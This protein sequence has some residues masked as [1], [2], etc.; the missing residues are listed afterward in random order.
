[1]KLK[2]VFCWSDISGYMAACWRALHDADEVEVFVIAFK[3]LTESAFGDRLMQD[4]PCRLLDLQ[5]RQ[6]A[7][8]IQQLVVAQQP[9]VVVVCGWL[10]QPYCQLVAVDRLKQAAFVMG[11]DTPWKDNWR[12][13]LAPLVLRSYLKQIDR[14]VVTGE[15]SWQYARHLGIEPGRIIR[16]L[17]GIDY[18]SWLPLWSQRSQSDWPRSFLFVGRYTP[19]K[20][21]D[22]LVRA[23]Q[24]Y[25]ARVADPWDLVCCGQ[26]DLKSLLADK[27]GIIDRGFMQPAEM[28]DVWRSAGAFILPSRFDPWP[29]AIVE[30][31]AAGLPIICTDVCGSAVEVVRSW[32]NG[33]VIPEEDPTQLTAALLIFDRYHAQL[34]LW[35][36]RSQELAAPYATSI[37]VERWQSL[38]REAVTA[39]ST[40]Q[41]QREFLPLDR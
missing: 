7:N 15:R 24:D 4:V 14:V 34:P 29:L 25:R 22:V 8:S 21:V 9:D 11:M 39:K 30:A 38:L 2:V 32:Y 12:Q 36:K 35:G 23:Y 6:D 27:P 17:Y 19:V 40:S 1:M 5:E 28:E 3:A 31:A 16:G 10:H 26:G 37:W 41:P 18:S 20:A 13:R 33:L